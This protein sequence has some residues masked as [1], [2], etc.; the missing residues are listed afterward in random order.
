MKITIKGAFPRKKTYEE[1]ESE[2]RS[3]KAHEERLTEMGR[4]L[5][6]SVRDQIVELELMVLEEPDEAHE[7]HEDYMEWHRNY[8][9]Q[10]EDCQRI[11]KSRLLRRRRGV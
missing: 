8:M 11:L 6:A 7:A 1:L 4:S 10:L 3:L 5:D 2:I 9:K